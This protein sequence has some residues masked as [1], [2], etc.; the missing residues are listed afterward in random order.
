[1]TE[2]ELSR[3][4]VVTSRLLSDLARSAGLSMPGEQVAARLRA[5][6]WL[7]PL[8]TRGAW[9]FAPGDRA[10]PLSGGDTFIEL[11]AELAVRPDL[12]IAVGYESAAFLRGL[13]SRQ[14][15]RQVI[16][17]APGT[18]RL[19]ALRAFRRVELDLP[20]AAHSQADGL[21]VQTVTAV[22]AA[23]AIR[24]DGFADWPGLAEWHTSAASAINVA[25]LQTFL[26]GR[27]AAAW[28]RAVYLLK[29]G[30]NL[31]VAESISANA[32][33]GN[34]PFY[35]GPRR[36]GGHFDAATRIIDTVVARYSTAHQGS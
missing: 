23:I 17:T 3:P 29:A 25:D 26:A 10:G 18:P 30:G 32:P 1:M 28:A 34:G 16:V 12:R 4:A 36:P 5:L 21:P 24:P 14:P 15:G 31:T 6:G 20:D 9:E 35:I 13:A 7:L 2:L 19:P 22:L 8:R 11:R 33:A 27:G